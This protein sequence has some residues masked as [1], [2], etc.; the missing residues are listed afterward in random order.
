MDRGNRPERHSRKKPFFVTDFFQSSF[1]NVG[2]DFSGRFLPGY[3]IASYCSVLSLLFW[4][5]IEFLFCKFL[6]S[7]DTSVGTVLFLSN[8]SVL[9]FLSIHSL[10]SSCI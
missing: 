10:P 7:C 3:A 9:V 4:S 6:R 5:C 1:R 2:E 8:I